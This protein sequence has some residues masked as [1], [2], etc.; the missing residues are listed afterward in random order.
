MFKDEVCF[1]IIFVTGKMYALYKIIKSGEHIENKKILKDSVD[2]PNK[3]KKGGQ[4]SV[5]FARLHDEKEDAYIKKLGELTIKSFM[6]STN[7]EQLIEKL[8]IAGPS[9]KKILLAK[10]ELIKQYFANKIVL[11]NT[12]DLNDQTIN[13]TLNGIRELFNSEN[14][15]NDDIALENIITLMSLADDKLIFGIDEIN[16]CLKNNEIRD[17]ITNPE[18]MSKLNITQNTKC[19][20]RVIDNIKLNKIGIDIVGIKW[21]ASTYQADSLYSLSCLA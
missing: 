13:E 15:N 12:P 7:T 17:L 2:L 5:R 4:S 6:N 14:D 10:N 21:Y 20:I 9:E 8:I 11:L 16:E 1:G 3:H 18:T 19:N